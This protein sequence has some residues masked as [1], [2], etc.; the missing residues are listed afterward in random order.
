MTSK[1]T[2]IIKDKKYDSH[3]N[4]LQLVENANGIEKDLF[5]FLQ[6]WYSSSDSIGIRSSGSTARSRIIRLSKKAMVSSAEA[7]CQFFGIGSNE[8]LHLCVPVQ[9]IAGK[10]MLVRALVSG[11][12]LIFEEPS[13]APLLEYRKQ[14]SF[15]AMTPMQVTGV[16]NNHP[17]RFQNLAQLIIG[18]APVLQALKVRLQLINTSCYATFGMTETATHVALNRLNGPRSSD[19]YEAVGDVSFNA[20]DRGCLIIESKNR[21]INNLFTN[22][23][24]DLKDRS[25]FRWLGRADYVINTGGLKVYPEVIEEKLS[26]E[27]SGNYFIASLPDNKL[28]EKVILLVEGEKRDICFDCLDKYEQPKQVYFIKKFVYTASGKIQ[29]LKTLNELIDA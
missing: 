22:D 1:Q 18:G 23:I 11:A 28:G 29:R 8:V 25:S 9:Y 3:S 21:E 14:I 24:V 27:I 2:I 19:I 5:S 15:S 7:T 20:D 26:R 17:E 10:M 16:L 6:D 13:A 4:Y 12:S